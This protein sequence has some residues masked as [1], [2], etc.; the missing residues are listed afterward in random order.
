MEYKRVLSGGA[1]FGAF[2][3]GALQVAEKMGYTNW[4]LVLNPTFRK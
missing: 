4:H 2:Q 1:V 3:I